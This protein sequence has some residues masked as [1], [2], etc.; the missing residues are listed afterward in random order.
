MFLFLKNNK[1]YEKN[2]LKYENKNTIDNIILL[3]LVENKLLKLLKDKNPPEEIIVNEKLKASKVLKFINLS[4]KKIT[5]VR[6]E[7]KITIFNDCFTISDE[8]NDI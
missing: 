3:I 6:R 7:Y 2:K 8:L 1:L 5:K 4:N